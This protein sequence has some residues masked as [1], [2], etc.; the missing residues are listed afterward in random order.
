MS[1]A[2]NLV[3]NSNFR[4]LKMV[5]TLSHRGNVATCVVVLV[6]VEEFMINGFKPGRFV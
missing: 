3:I 5:A 4:G 1:S 6:P 2:S